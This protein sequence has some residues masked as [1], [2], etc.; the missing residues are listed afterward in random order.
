MNRAAVV[1]EGIVVVAVGE[2][3]RFEDLGHRIR[4]TV[5]AVPGPTPRKSK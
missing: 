2:V 4:Q 5:V 3:D 1:G